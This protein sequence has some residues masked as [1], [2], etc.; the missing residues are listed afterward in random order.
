MNDDPCYCM[1]AS[2]VV[3]PICIVPS[4]EWVDV[5]VYDHSHSCKQLKSLYEL[6]S[7]PNKAKREMKK[8]ARDTPRLT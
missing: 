1:P 8:Y 7:E 5:Y 4:V 6:K 2:D 3:W